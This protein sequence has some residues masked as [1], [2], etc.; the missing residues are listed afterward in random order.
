MRS[1]GGLTTRRRA[2]VLACLLLGASW[3]GIGPAGPLPVGPR[4]VAAAEYKLVTTATYDVR[5]ADEAVNVTIGVTFRN[6]TPNP[7]G[8]FSVFEVIDLAVHEGARNLR[9]RDADGRLQASLQVRDGVTVASI[10]PREGVR[11]RDSVKF[12]FSYTLAD[13]AS[14]DVRIRP[15]VVIFPVWSF[16]TVGHVDVELPREYEVLVDGDSLVADRSG[17]S[18][19][20]KSGTI[21]D[22]T[23][24]LSLLTATLPSSYATLSGSVTLAAG[25]LDLEVRAWSDDRPWGRRTIALL[26][27]ALPL[28]E[29]ELGFDYRPSGPLVVVESLPLAGGE[30]SEPTL[31][32]TDVAIGFDEPAF[33][34][35][36]QLAHAWLSPAL[37]QDR[38]IREGFAS[39]AAAAV[40]GKLDVRLPYDPSR[41]ARERKADAFPLV[42]WGAGESS[43]SQD[44]FAYAA[45]WSVAEQ[46]TDR[47]GAAA[48]RRAWRR[49]VGGLDAYRPLDQEPNLAGGLPTAPLDS[50][51]LLDQLEAVSGRDL[52]AVFKEWVFDPA[53]IDRLPAR[54]AA[55]DALADLLARSGE[56]GTPDPVRLALAGWRFGDAEAAMAEATAWLSDRDQ[57]LNDIVAAGLTAPARL[58]DEYQTGGGSQAARDELEAE[59][60]VV[61]TYVEAS[62]LLEGTPSIVEQAGL[63]GGNQPGVLLA[64]ARDFFAE[65]DLVGAGTAATQALDR[66]QVAGQDGTVRIASAATLLVLLLAFLIA[67]VRRRRRA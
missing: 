36:H 57:L 20:L 56:L 35:V 52:S 65:G 64:E 6:T 50:R 7:A 63:L 25:K 53:T 41:E 21:E 39:N 37:V 47:I 24:W 66:L 32:G 38:W 14:R 19:Q 22:P 12:T 11:Y 67:Q 44:R 2:A 23:R 28:L 51:Q 55:R 31:D 15:S 34:V 59:R 13:G 58:D 1:G 29:E 45:S 30:L 48:I 49:I 9:A 18:L 54:A 42:S 5:P 62:N 3:L 33:T 10:R 46:L 17:E 43:A 61:S 26:S 8:R 16:G 60:T 27:A 4:P 40:A